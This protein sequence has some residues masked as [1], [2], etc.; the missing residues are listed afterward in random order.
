MLTLTVCNRFTKFLPKLDNERL[1]PFDIIV[2][3]KDKA[4]KTFPWVLSQ[5]SHSWQRWS[6]L[7]EKLG[8][9]LL[10]FGV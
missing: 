6:D 7:C 4:Y 9:H 8:I 1:N 2:A 10:P 5:S 3:A